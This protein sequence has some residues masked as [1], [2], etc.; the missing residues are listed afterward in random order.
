MSY[1][2]HSIRVQHFM[3]FSLQAA[4]RVGLILTCA[5]VVATIVT[6]SI[7]VQSTGQKLNTDPFAV[8]ASIMP[9]QQVNYTVLEADGFSCKEDTHPTPADLAE[10]CSDDEGDQQI[11]AITVVIWDAIVKHLDLKPSAGTFTM[12]DMALLWGK[13]EIQHT[14]HAINLLW[15][16]RRTSAGGW[17]ENE[18][19]SYFQPVSVLSFGL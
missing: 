19:F 1:L 12:G 8:Y 13:P 6:L 18:Q 3:G 10:I 15:R 2:R 4:L 17:S 11:S 14:G 7:G 5:H 9:G 16:A